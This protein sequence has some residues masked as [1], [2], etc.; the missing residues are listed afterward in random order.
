M[1]SYQ[2]LIQKAQL[3]EKYFIDV[4]RLD[5]IDPEISGN[6]WFKLK[7]NIQ[8]ANQL[9]HHCVL[10]FG[11]A[12]SNH[13]AATAKACKIYNLKSIGVI[14][15]DLNEAA[16]PT[17][18]RAKE[19]GMQILMVSRADYRKKEDPTFINEL[20]E[21]FG[22]FYLIPEGG[23]NKEGILGCKEILKPEWT[24]D[25]IFCPCGTG[26]TYAGL[27]ASANANQII[28]GI[29]VLK[30]NNAM[31]KEVFEKLLGIDK[32]NTFN[33]KGNEA[34]EVISIQQHC[35]LNKYAFSGYAKHDQMLVD[36]KKT[37]ESKNGFLLDY[38]YTN[39]LFFAVNDLIQQKKINTTSK[40]L[41]L[42]T[43]GLQ[44]NTAFEKRF[45]KSD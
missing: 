7:Y 21:K 4:L 1:L 11:G 12:H 33:I 41:V 23:N 34:Q 19:N 31:P 39:K 13:I 35:I 36:F 27:L 2:T 42:H 28:V 29:N 40:I 30:G 10:T 25:Y 22:D 44:G 8:K 17:L 16:S 24:Y 37:F 9:K 38:V 20:K 43:G 26:A 18:I 14:R 15:G 6:K 5:L 3:N 45:L 32:T